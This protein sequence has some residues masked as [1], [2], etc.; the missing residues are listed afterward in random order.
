MA[1]IKSVEEV[2]S[3]AE[4]PWL[5]P[6]DALP[7][8][9]QSFETVLS[10]YEERRAERIERT[11]GEDFDAEEQ[12]AMEEEHEAE[13]ELL[14][15]L[16]E[17]C[18]TILREYGDSAMPLV[19]GLMPSIGRLLEKGR[20]AEERRVALC[21]MDDVIQYSPSGAAKYMQQVM[22]LLLEG[23]SGREPVI[24]QC[25]VYGLGQAANHR[26][27]GFR[28]HAPTALTSIVAMINA[29]DARSDDN[30]AATENAVSAL[31]KILEHLPDCV[32]PSLGTVFVQNLPLE[33][34]EEEAKEAH[35]L[36]LRLVR[37]S[38][39]R[40][41]G[42]SN[43][44]LPKLVDIMV[45]VLAK[46]ELLVKPEDAAGMVTL[47]KQMQG[48]LPVEMFNMYVEAL[49]PKQRATL[50]NILSGSALSL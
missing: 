3:F 4:G 35:G 8:V 16:G 49:K 38:D 31:G 30:L 17:A 48:A 2:L 9:F 42:G 32:D 39:P 22:P 10:D 14:D 50:Q 28:P 47:L 6:V 27:D 44:N 5:L 40:I 36:L 26:G 23:A 11:A 46:G 12:E 21:L 29:P 19:E 15:K 37:A 34:D 25:C 1:M 7:P 20:Y 45:R 41:L 43:A 24:R 18:T 33:E 13:G